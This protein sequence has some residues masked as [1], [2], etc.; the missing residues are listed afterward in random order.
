MLPLQVLR[1]CSNCQR[2]LQRKKIPNKIDCSLENLF[3][4]FFLCKLLRE[5]HWELS[6]AIHLKMLFAIFL[7]ISLEIPNGVRS[8]IRQCRY[9]IPSPILKSGDSF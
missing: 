1:R 7:I 2:K 9:E 6:W 5:I 4:N 8:I 3:K